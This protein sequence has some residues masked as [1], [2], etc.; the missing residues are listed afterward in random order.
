MI[1]LFA[2]Q[3]SYAMRASEKLLIR[4]FSLKTEATAEVCPVF[5]GVKTNSPSKKIKTKINLGLYSGAGNV[6]RQ[7]TLDKSF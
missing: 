2:W 4:V 7:K 5:L 1:L 3:Y 6:R